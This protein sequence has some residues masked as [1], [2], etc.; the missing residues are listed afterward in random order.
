MNRSKM[1]AKELSRNRKVDPVEIELM[2]KVI[3]AAF[4]LGKT[5]KEVVEEILEESRVIDGII[6]RCDEKACKKDC[7]KDCRSNKSNIYYN[8]VE[9]I[10]STIDLLTKLLL[11]SPLITTEDDCYELTTY[12]LDIKRKALD[13]V[14]E[15]QK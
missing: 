2:R 10:Y 9:V 6:E 14:K 15:L 7:K 11:G 1:L 12:V 5:W 3:M 4:T 8:V 13:K